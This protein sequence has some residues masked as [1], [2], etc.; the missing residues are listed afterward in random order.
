MISLLRFWFGFDERVD[1]R[2]YFRHG[3]ALMPL[4]YLVDFAAVRLI[5]SRTWTPLDYVQPLISARK[6]HLGPSPSW[7][8]FALGAWALPFLWIGISRTL[9]RLVDAAWPPWLCLLFFVPADV[10]ERRRVQSA[11]LGV[12]GSGRPWP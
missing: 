5:T 9:R 2:S 8:L 12:A 10:R 3:L 6:E 1:R 4:K 7:F 11:L